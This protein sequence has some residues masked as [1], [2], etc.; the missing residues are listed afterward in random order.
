VSVPS[1]IANP[2]LAAEGV[3]RIEWADREM[4]VLRLI[5]ERFRREQ[6]LKGS[7]MSAC[8]HVTTSRRTG[9]HAARRGADLRLVRATRFRHR[10]MWAAALVEEYGVPVFAIGEDNETYYRHIHQAL[11]HS[12]QLTW[13]TARTWWRRC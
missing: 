10:T 1:D 5:R 11:G 6:P 4:P 9:D 8:L 7:R 13:T 3:R 2:R 12:P